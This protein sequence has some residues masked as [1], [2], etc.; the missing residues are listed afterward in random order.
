[1]DTSPGIE[2]AAE[3]RAG[4]FERALMSEVLPEAEADRGQL[5]TASPTA[6]VTHLLV[7]A[8][9]CGEDHGRSHTRSS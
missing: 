1:M 3:N 8:G 2:R 6:A 9:S 7:T 5:Q 4:R